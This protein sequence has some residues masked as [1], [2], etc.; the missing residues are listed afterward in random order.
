MKPSIAL[1]PVIHS[2]NLYPTLFHF[3]KHWAKPTESI[4]KPSNESQ[5]EFAKHQSVAIS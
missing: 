4:L 3:Q 2:E 1:L 5:P